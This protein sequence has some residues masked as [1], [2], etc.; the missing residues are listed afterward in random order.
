[1][2]NNIYSLYVLNKSGGLVY[3]QHFQTKEPYNVPKSTNECLTLVA[4]EIKSLGIEVIE[5]DTFK[6]QCYTAPTATK[7]FL[8]ADPNASS[9]GI[10]LKNIYNLYA[11]Y[12]MK[13][14][15]R[16]L[17]SEKQKNSFTMLRCQ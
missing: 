13:N 11:D 7:F 6:L 4:P 12:V 3:H 17:I 1:M 15:V 2:V 9:L 8:I 16:F 14:P 5:T 10:T